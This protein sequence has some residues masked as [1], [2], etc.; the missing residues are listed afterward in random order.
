MEIV[1]EIQD[2]LIS[3]GGALVKKGADYIYKAEF[4]E[5]ETKNMI[6]LARKMCGQDCEITIDTTGNAVDEVKNIADVVIGS[7]DED[8]IAVFIED[9]ILD[10]YAVKV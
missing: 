8:G 3:S 7:N 5:A 4:S 1:Q 9:S 2:I 6:A 10:S